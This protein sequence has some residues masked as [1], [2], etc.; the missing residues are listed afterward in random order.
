MFV[1]LRLNISATANIIWGHGDGT[2]IYSLIRH[3]TSC[4]STEDGQRLGILDL[5]SRGIAL[6]L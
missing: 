3:K 1:D 6:P 2:S 5:E 4:A